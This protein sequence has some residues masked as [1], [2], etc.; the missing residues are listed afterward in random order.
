MKFLAWID[1]ISEK[2]GRVLSY[3][4]I[5]LT[6]AVAIDVVMRYFFKSPTAWAFDTALH[7]YSIPFVIGGTWVLKN[8]MHIRVDIFIDR[9]PPKVKSIINL[10]FYV[11]LL[12]PICIILIKHGI[13]YAH[14]SWVAKEVSRF[15]P[16]HPPI[17]P[18]K[19]IIPIAF[20][21]LLLQG[22]AEFIREIRNLVKGG[23]T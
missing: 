14:S 11:A 22:I 18:L 2:S 15:T 8:R 19:T 6:F 13:I 17:Y 4:F 3:F 20:S 5:L 16:L 23:N 7:L 12:F 21:M 9:F 10:F 1:A